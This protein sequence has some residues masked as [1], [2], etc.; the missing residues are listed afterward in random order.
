MV[1]LSSLKLVEEEIVVADDAQYVDASEF[2]PPIPA[3]MYTLVQGKP[4]F[5]ATSNGY[6]Q[7]TMTHVVAGGEHDGAKLAFDRVSDKPFD[8]QG[9]K[10]SMAADHVRAVYPVGER[11]T[12]RSHADYA[13]AIEGAEGKPFK[14]QVD[15]EAGCNHDGT[16]QACEW[17]DDKVFRV[18]GERNFPPSPS[19]QGKL[20]EIK[21]TVC[22][23][24]VQARTRIVRRL[25]A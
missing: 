1:D 3:G 22:G 11:P 16:P 17:T 14:A 5:T 4:D 23:T 9:I 13:A 19:G 2:P 10:V 24:V 21:C 18:K 8:R 25:P 15:W 20:S 6:L 7:A 12:C